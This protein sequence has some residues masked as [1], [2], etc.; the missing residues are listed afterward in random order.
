MLNTRTLAA[1]AAVAASCV[2]LPALAQD[3]QVTPLD[4]TAKAPT[5]IVVH[6]RDR[7]PSAVRHDIRLAANSVCTNA[8]TNR[9]LRFTDHAWCSDTATFKANKRYDAVTRTAAYAVSGTIL[10]SAR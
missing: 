2:A 5:E 1:V 6:F 9:E 10:L 3:A 8:V 4:I 7:S